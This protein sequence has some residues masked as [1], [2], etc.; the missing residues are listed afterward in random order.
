MNCQFLAC[1]SVLA[2]PLVS[3]TGQMSAAV[4]NTVDGRRLRPGADTLAIYLIRGS[5]TV[6]TGTVIDRLWVDDAR[7][8]RVY[9]SVDQ[10]LGNR[11]DTIV[12]RLTDLRPI[13]YRSRSSRLAAQLVFDRDTVA[14]WL[15]LV[16]GDSVAVRVPLAG[17]VYDAA[18]FDLVARASDLR[19]DLRLAVA[20]FL[21][22]SNTVG[23]LE[24]RVDGSAD[25]D[26]R[27]CW[28]FK[29]VFGGLPVSFWIDKESRT[30]RRQLMQLG[31]DTSVLFAVPRAATSP[32]RAT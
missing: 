23:S 2:L 18:S 19:D 27:A 11:L 25:V 5:D 7:L 22:G 29:A 8:N 6:R 20:S 26:G 16:S 17:T 15:R 9:S 24:G 21:V 10:V 1:V 31:V 28:V 13:S 14:G 4:P 32:K 3:A 30:L 12:S